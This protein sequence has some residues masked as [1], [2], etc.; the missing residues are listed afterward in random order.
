MNL[1]IPFVNALNFTVVVGALV[2]ILK[3]IQ[4][5]AGELATQEGY[6][7]ELLSIVPEGA[8]FVMMAVGGAFVLGFVIG[9]IVELIVSLFEK[10]VNKVKEREEIQ[11]I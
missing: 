11:P 4:S 10:T 5:K 6:S 2:A 8:G 9:L 3:V 1:R 7:G